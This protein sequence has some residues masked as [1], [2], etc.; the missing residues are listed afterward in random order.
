MRLTRKPGQSR[1]TIGVLLIRSRYLPAWIGALLLL[2]GAGYIANSAADLLMPSLD[3]GPWL[4]L[5]GLVGEGALTLQFENRYQCKDGSYKWI[6]WRANPDFTLGL[7]H[8][9]ARNMTAEKEHEFEREQMLHQVQCR[10]VEPLQIV[11]KQG[12]GVLRPSEYTDK[13]TE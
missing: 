2:S 10:R 13:A 12:K 3:L 4:L 8:F 9:V 11:E 6:S 1:T 5:P 7:I